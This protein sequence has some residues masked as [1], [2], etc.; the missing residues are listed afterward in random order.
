MQDLKISNPVLARY[1]D[2]DQ[3]PKFQSNVTVQLLRQLFPLTPIKELTEITPQQVGRVLG[4]KYA[5]IFALGEYAQSLGKDRQAVERGNAIKGKMQKAAPLTGADKV[6]EETSPVLLLV[7]EFVT[8]IMPKFED[9][10]QQS[11]KAALKRGNY[12]EALDFF[13]GFA[14]GFAIK[15]FKDGKIVRTTEATELH[16]RMFM[17]SQRIK[18]LRTVRELRGFL[19]QNGFTEETLRDDERLQ[20]Y[21]YRIRYAP[22][23]R[24]RPAKSKK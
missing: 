21:C 23:K 22:G 13:R 18:K 5:N 3:A 17:E 8:N 11:F 19:L 2:P 4:H 14:E 15:G 7:H 20:K 10:V 24:G 6:R 12:Q 16:L 9:V 1:L